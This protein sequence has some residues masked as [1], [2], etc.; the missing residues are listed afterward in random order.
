MK[1]GMG[2]VDWGGEGHRVD[3]ML[4]IGGYGTGPE[5]GLIR[6]SIAREIG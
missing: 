4:D 3:P 5:G 2:G 6:V 1:D